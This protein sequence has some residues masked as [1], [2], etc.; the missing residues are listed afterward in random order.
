MASARD[1]AVPTSDTL[2][3]AK[4]GELRLTA[5]LGKGTFSRVYCAVSTGCQD[6]LATKVVRLD[7][8]D[9]RSRGMIESELQIICELGPH[10]YIIPVLDVIQQD[11]WVAIVMPVVSGGDL[12]QWVNKVQFPRLFAATA[13]LQASMAL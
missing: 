3:S 9:A 10:P 1:G 7:T 5:V 13:Y 6:P 2:F 11:T 4:F 8:L 12:R